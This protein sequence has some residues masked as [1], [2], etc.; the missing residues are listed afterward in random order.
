MPEEP[1]SRTRKLGRRQI[2]QYLADLRPWENAE[3]IKR[4]IRPDRRPWYARRDVRKGV[5]SHEALYHFIDKASA[6][7]FYE[8]DLMGY[9]NEHNRDPDWPDEELI[10]FD[11]EHYH[12]KLLKEQLEEKLERKLRNGDLLARGFSSNAALDSPRQAIAPER[13]NDL[14]LDSKTSTAT[15]P[16]LTITQILVFGKPSESPG[17][18][19]NLRVPRDAI[20]AWY[21]GWVAANDGKGTAPTRDEDEAAARTEFGERVTRNILRALRRELAPARWTMRGRRR[22]VPNRKGP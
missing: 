19:S 5:P 22:E 3:E 20:R 11:S 6:E 9:G 14:D 18:R 21:V 16:N 1:R 17:K 15:G 8:L 13:W 7:K 4:G 10:R 2:E 12:W